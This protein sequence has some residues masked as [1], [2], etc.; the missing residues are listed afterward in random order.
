[1]PTL[2]RTLMVPLAA[3]AVVLA[4]TGTAAAQPTDST[5]AF[6]SLTT[7]TNPAWMGHV[8]DSTS[9]A[10]LSIPGTHDT[11]AIEGGLLPSAYEAQQDEGISAQTLTAQLDAGIRAIDIRVRIVNN[12]TAFAIHHTDVYEDANFDDVLTK[13]QAFLAA[14]PSET[15]LMD[16]HGE[17]DGDTTEG[18]VGFSIPGKCA[19]D[20]S[21]AT[22]AMRESIFQSYVARYPG[23][24]YAP[25]VTGSSTADMPTLGQVRGHIVLSTFTGPVGEVY[26]GY[27]LTRLTTGNWGQYV[28]NNWSQCDLAGKW[29]IAQTNIQHAAADPAN[30]YT[31]YL[32]AN[33]APFG[34]GPADMAGGYN[35][36]VGEDQQALS[37]LTSGS[38]GASGVVLMDY[39]G[40]ALINAVIGLNPGVTPSSAS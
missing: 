13:A 23:L 16:L 21:N 36:G 14:N 15:I 7:A 8:A 30:M 10:A 3:A 26:A 2:R 37:Y 22:T 34:A 4:C 19:D 38:V 25:S 24:F 18:G 9:L 11:L 17:C 40:Y 28:E 5:P 33:C 1:M 32:S 12:G 39:P 35:G 6:N 20:P 31:T 27:G 29:G